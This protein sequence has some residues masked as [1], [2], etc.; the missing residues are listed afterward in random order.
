PGLGT[1]LGRD[2]EDLQLGNISFMDFSW[3]M[4]KTVSNKLRR[5]A[6]VGPGHAAQGRRRKTESVSLGLLP[7]E[8]VEVRS[9]KEIEATLDVSGKNRGLLFTP[10]ML[11][12]C[13]RRFYV[14]NRL[15]KMIL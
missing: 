3:H 4:S 13:G 11:Q 2:L 7:G 9:R 1:R 12:Y 10:P 6:G 5:L 8:L 15:Q 14:A